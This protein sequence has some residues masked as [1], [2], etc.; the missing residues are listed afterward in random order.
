MIKPVISPSGTTYE[1]DAV[2]Q[3]INRMGN[4]DPMTR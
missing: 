3:H 1:A 4:F 2:I